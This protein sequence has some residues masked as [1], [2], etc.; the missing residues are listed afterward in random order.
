MYTPKQ[1]IP[2]PYIFRDSIIPFVLSLG[3]SKESVKATS[4]KNVSTGVLDENKEH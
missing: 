3:Q 1:N 4:M 2:N